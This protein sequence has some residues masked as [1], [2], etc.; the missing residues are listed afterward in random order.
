MRK[1]LIAAASS[2]A[3]F[4]V[5]PQAQAHG[6]RVG[7][8]V[9]GAVT[10]AVVSQVLSAHGH[11]HYYVERRPRVIEHHYYEAPRRSREVHHYYHERSRGHGHWKHDHRG[12]HRAAYRHHR[13]D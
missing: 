10:G 8:F 3:L 1:F 4:A 9:A 13:Y 7:V 5:V 2:L 11:D 6:D 12:G